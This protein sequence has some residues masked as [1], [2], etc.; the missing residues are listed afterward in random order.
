M[1]SRHVRG[2]ARATALGAGAALVAATLLGACKEEPPPV[3][4]PKAEVPAEKKPAVDD[5][6]ANA[7]AA[8][9]ANARSESGAPSGQGAPPPDGIL[10]AAAAARELAPAARAWRRR[11]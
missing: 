7:M 1:I 10:G 2:H 6:I 8:A 11:Q 4:E 9:E 5:K 3:T